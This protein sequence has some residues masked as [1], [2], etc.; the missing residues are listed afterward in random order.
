MRANYESV[1]CKMLCKYVADAGLQF[2]RSMQ[3]YLSGTSNWFVI[4]VRGSAAQLPSVV[5][6]YELG[7]FFMS[8]I[9]APSMLIEWK[10]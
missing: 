10:M 5:E 2:R 6:Q 8:V 1:Y 4:S 7:R 3:H 9:C